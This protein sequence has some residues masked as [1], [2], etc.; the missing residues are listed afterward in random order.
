MIK[1][2]SRNNTVGEH[3]MTVA[4]AKRQV[5][6]PRSS[7]GT[8]QGT[9]PTAT[10][11]TRTNL[12]TVHETRFAVSTVNHMSYPEIPRWW[13]PRAGAP[14]E[15]L[16]R[17]RQVVHVE[18][19]FGYGVVGA[20]IHVFGDGVPLYLLENWSPGSAASPDFLREL[21]SRMLNSRYAVVPFTGRQVELGQLR[22]WRQTGPRLAVRWL[23]GPGGQGKTRL[24]AEFAADSMAAG[25][26]V[27]TATHGPG[28]VLPPPGSQDLCLGNAAGLLLLVDYA[29]RWPLTHLTW[30]FSNALL[31][32]LGMPTR[33]LL[34]AR[35]TDPW[36]AIRASLANEQAG[37]S[38]QLLE[39]L[40]VD[41]SRPRVEMFT[42]AR[43]SFA[44]RYGIRSAAGIAPP[45][46]L[47]E[48]DFGLTL[49]L[50]M[51]AL[52]AVDASR[53]GSRPPTDLAN[54]AVYLLDRE[55]LHWARLY[56]DST[57]E[58]DPTARV[59]RTP[60]AVMNQTVFTAALT[61]PVEHPTG[62][63]V[64][65]RILR[66]PPAEQVIADHAVCYPSP[67][68]IR[69]TVLEPLNPDRL[70]EDFLALTFPGHGA[71]YPVQ[72]WA[73]PTATTLLARGPHHLPAAWTPR[74]IM[75]LTSAAGRWP[76]LG[77]RHLYPILHSDPQLAVAAGSA[78]LSALASMADIG[79]ELLEEIAAH[80]PTSRAV[81]L[82]PGIADIA[83]R[84]ARHRLGGTDDPAVRAR[85]HYDLA[86]RLFYA[87]HGDEALAEAR[88]A[89]A[90]YR[91]LAV[92]NPERYGWRL[93]ASLAALAGHLTLAHPHE[94]VAAGE[95]A[96]Q[97]LRRSAESG[98]RAAAINLARALDNYSAALSQVGRR[99]EAM[100]AAGDALRIMDQL[101]S[102]ASD[103]AT[104][105]DDFASILNNYG[106][107]QDVEDAGQREKA[108]FALSEATKL[109]RRLTE[110]NP[111]TFM[112]ELAMSLHNLGDR[113]AE[114]GRRDEAVAATAE[115]AQIYRRIAEVNP[116]AFEV[117][118]GQTLEHLSMH[119]HEGGR[120]EDAVQTAGEATR[121]H[122]RLAEKKPH[123]ST[124]G[125]ARSLSALGVACHEA[126]HKQEALTA[127]EEAV[128]IY[129][130]LAQFDPE[131][132]E[133]GVAGTLDHLG[134]RLAK[135]QRMKEAIMAADEAA[136]I[137]RRI[138]KSKPELYAS[139][140]AMTLG[141]LGRHLSRSGQRN[142]AIAAAEE[143]V[144]LFRQQAHKNPLRFA[145]RLAEALLAL[146]LARLAAR[147][148]LPR[149][150][151]ALHEGIEILIPFARA[152]PHIFG[153]RLY[154]QYKVA[155]IFFE[156][157]GCK[158]E[159]DQIRR[160][161]STS[162]PNSNLLVFHFDVQPS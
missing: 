119:F 33:V 47:D 90:L 99:T 155:A 154:E 91:Q 66:Q 143:A 17:P 144:H 32:Q 93:G 125:L 118:L 19:G 148:D 40:P 53:T 153:E 25:W 58:L 108:I 18:S 85:I 132:Y 161:V 4:A 113:L 159:A 68:P 110:A 56:G 82:D 2:V 71:D 79:P 89:T 122:R 73:A 92:Q 151:E 87:G 60:P 97:I 70:A 112:P 13:N 74:A 101:A 138:W 31:H 27:V 22:E 157:V 67:D 107:F 140:F 95:E 127:T 156:V 55:Q 94:A 38:T 49:A 105:A 104:W 137:Y 26:K 111:Q 59:F 41:E 139:N 128:R 30:L 109:Y 36:P 77:P 142:E 75:L 98:P 62:T 3:R 150:W 136:R 46:T 10:D 134:I 81:D 133:A 24:A 152:E 7:Y 145:P 86:P 45:S 135:V 64:V 20:D 100:A 11:K 96:V 147:Q 51:A 34:L 69:D 131:R 160:L 141:N 44:S 146:A 28:T 8:V 52:V 1:Y 29:D 21:P 42:V 120:Q 15:E 63:D 106:C 121:V 57:H 16:V 84:I 129:R 88:E 39:P 78:A 50:H 115:A 12:A 65:A 6:E 23:H 114:A 103:D 48:P 9:C 54:L 72:G 35:T 149:V 130:R 61:G 76:H 117:R 43:D 14:D 123:E 162:D 83:A 102:A 5:S 158:A 80:F 124:S 116:S 126:G 37:T